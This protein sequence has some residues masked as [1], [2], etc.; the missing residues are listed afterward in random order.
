[1]KEKKTNLKLYFIGITIGAVIGG[2]AAMLLEKSS[3]LE[4]SEPHLNKKQLSR[5]GF[6]IV[7]LL[8]SLIETGKGSPNNL[9]KLG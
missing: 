2:I 5:L 1:M 9:K 7:A 3:G 6:G 8:S 4:G